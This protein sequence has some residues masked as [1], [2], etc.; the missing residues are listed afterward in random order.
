MRK[1]NLLLF[2]FLFAVGI[3]LFSCNVGNSGNNYTN[4]DI[5]AVVVDYSMSGVILGT[6]YGYFSAPELMT[7]FPGTGDCLYLQQFTVDLDNQPQNTQYTVI[8]DVIQAGI[9][10]WYAEESDAIMDIANYT[11]PISSIDEYW[12]TPFYNG[13]IFVGFTTKGKSQ[14][15]RLVYNN[16]KNDANGAKNLYFLAE[17]AS[18]GSSSSERT[19][20][21]FDLLSLNQSLWNDTTIVDS[22]VS[23]E[24]KYIKAN[25]NYL[26]AI[27][28]ADT[29]YTP[30]PNNP[31]TIMVF[32]NKQ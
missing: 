29:T 14:N 16:T 4:Y 11:L 7:A 3:G 22:G 21:A 28:D 13:K 1:Q 5:P 20:Q 12:S 27:T 32:K 8:T 24:L 30:I 9:D 18:S 31:F 25:L 26:S 23:F 6:P 15:F 2:P 19:L 10:K 17:P